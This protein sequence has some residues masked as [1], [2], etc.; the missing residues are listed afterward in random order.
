MNTLKPIKIIENEVHNIKISNLYLFKGSNKGYIINSMNGIGM[1]ISSE[2]YSEIENGAFSDELLSKMLSRGLIEISGHN[3][4]TEDETE[5]KTS[6]FLIDMTKRC[7]MNCIYCL[8]NPYAENANI[9]FEMMDKI[10]DKIIEYCHINN[11]DMIDIQPWGGETFL[12]KEKIFYI[13]KKLDQDAP[14]IKASISVETNGILLNDELAEQ[15]KKYNIKVGVSIDGTGDIHDQQRRD[16]LNNPTFE[17]VVNGIECLHKHGINNIGTISVITSE[18]ISHIDDIIDFFISR[19]PYVSFKLN[20][21]HS[22]GNRKM[23]YLAI[24]DDKCEEMIDRIMNCILLYEKKGHIIKDGNVI[25]GLNNL[26]YRKDNNICHSHGCMGG[27]KMIIF[28]Q[29]GDIYP[30]ELLDYPDIKLGNVNERSDI[31]TMI[32]NALDQNSFFLKKH[33]IKCSDCPW[34]YYCQGG[35]TSAV[36]YEN[37]VNNG[38]I[39][40]DSCRINKALYERLVWL[41]TE[42]TELTLKIIQKE[43]EGVI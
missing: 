15:I 39:S 28:D 21:M 1:L 18:S 27:K 3:D 36:I 25:C 6:F 17:K 41:L 34:N 16:L 10:V 4:L 23:N 31:G 12:E 11:V 30:C 29:K 8:R 26:I 20:H 19:L 2:F 5:F 22:P 42:K 43:K 9:S 32:R 33:D 38:S 37:G 24:T 40:V 14:D 7:N 35:C 13:R